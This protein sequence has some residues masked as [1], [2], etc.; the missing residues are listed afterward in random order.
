MTTNRRLRGL[1]TR[2]SATFLC[3]LTFIVSSAPTSPWARGSPPRGSAAGADQLR[4]YP[5]DR[6]LFVEA[7]T[8]PYTVPARFMTTGINA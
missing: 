4:D 5:A 3:A 1:P 7:Y 2:T 8:S 6:I